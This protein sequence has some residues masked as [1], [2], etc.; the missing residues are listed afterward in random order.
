MSQY[1]VAFRRLDMTPEEW[2]LYQSIVQSYTSPTN[3][4]EDLFHDLFETDD[5][6]IITLLKPPTTKRSSFEV[7]LFLV[8]LYVQQHIR[9]MYG[10]IAEMADQIKDKLAEIDDKLAKLTKTKRSK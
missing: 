9:L 4:G 3:K 7:V 8:N 1:I 5:N 6:G 2:E 10:E